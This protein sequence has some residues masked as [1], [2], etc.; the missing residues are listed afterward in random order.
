MQSLTTYIAQPELIDAAVVAELG[1]MVERYPSFQ[2]ARLL[3]LRG[4]YLLQ[5]KRFGQELSRAAISMPDRERLFE[6]FETDIIEAA[7][8][9]DSRAPAE[10]ARTEGAEKA[11]AAQ[12]ADRTLSL[13]DTFLGGR[14]QQV[15]TRHPRPAEAAVDYT[16]YLLQLEDAQPV[17]PA[18]ARAAAVAPQQSDALPAGGGAGPGP[19][20][21]DSD[22]EEEAEES[23]VNDTSNAYFTE[24]LARIYIKQRKYAKAIEIIRRI[25]LR[26]PQK[27]PYFADQIRFLEKLV[28]NESHRKDPSK[29]E[30]EENNNQIIS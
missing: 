20:A 30:N 11:D 2:A 10:A 18:P 28:L 14:P 19:D 26:Y 25:S 15:S 4:L 22:T 9:A 3:Y 6:L 12:P 5:D 27:S 29:G 17:A 13:I 21:A 23:N 8:E 1:E 24:T 16:V 7:A